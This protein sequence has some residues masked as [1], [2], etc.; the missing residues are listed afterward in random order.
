MATP[1]PPDTLMLQIARS[2]REGKSIIE[3][4][5]AILGPGNEITEVIYKQWAREALN[6]TRA[7]M[8]GA[9]LSSAQAQE[10]TQGLRSLQQGE[11]AGSAFA[12]WLRSLLPGSGEAGGGAA[13]G[14]GSGG[15]LT[16]SGVGTLGT[17]S[18]GTVATLAGLGAAALLIGGAIYVRSGD[19]AV[20]AGPA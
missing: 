10:I 18:L 8:G 17:V 6:G 15:M 12:R 16:Y 14:T 19:K 13:A 2:L 20:Q 4:S 3:A 11:S 1:V 5:R 7:A 9:Q